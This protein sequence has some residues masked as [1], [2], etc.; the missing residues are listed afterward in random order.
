MSGSVLFDEP[1]P[2]GK[3][4]IRIAS[5][6][7][8]VVLAAVVF[9]ALRQFASHGQLDAAR[10]EPFGQWP[11]WS[12]LL[13]GLRGTLQAAALVAVLGAAFGMVLALGRLSP[14][15]AV[16]WAAAT[17]IEIARTLPVLLLIYVTLFA[18][19]AYG[20]N[21]P[22]L[23]KLVL[24]L[25]VANAAA[26]AEIFRAGI[27]SMPRGQNE[28]ALSL[29]MTRAQSMRLVVLPQ[30]LRA[31]APSVVSQLVSL[32]KDT[33]LGFI[34]A[35]TELLYRAQVLAAYNHLL[36]QTYLVVT[37]VYLVCNLSLSGVAHRLQTF[38]RRRTAAPVPEKTP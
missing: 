8:V 33:S 36:V 6:V 2:R 22:L 28:A 10:W 15:R 9:L 3:R 21:L 13:V 38:T 26:F 34:V 20:L 1:G 11:I 35:F 5:V 37:L 25:T 14:V 30:A 31:V 17:Y 24:P 16:R 18:L 23:W 12:Y 32:L 4:R 29:G 27:L 19:P 7:T